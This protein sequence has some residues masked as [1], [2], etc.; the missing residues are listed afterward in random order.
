MESVAKSD[1]DIVPVSYPEDTEASVTSLARAFETDP[2]I[3]YMDSLVKDPKTA[4]IRYQNR[5]TRFRNSMERRGD[6]EIESII[7]KVVHI[8]TGDIVGGCYWVKPAPRSSEPTAE[9]ADALPAHLEPYPMVPLP[10]VEEALN[11]LAKGLDP[12]FEGKAHEFIGPDW[13][14]NW[15]NLRSLGVVPEH[16]FKGLGTKMVQWGIEL[17][18]EDARKRPGLIKGVWVAATAAGL[19]T[20]LKAGMKEVGDMMIDYGTDD[21]V[22]G[23]K[24]VYLTVEF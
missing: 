3:I 18:R 21:G 17:V 1:Y 4:G 5:I 15:W 11:R 23:P 8:P 22:A 20:Y 7:G 19:K 2:M 13:K 6:Q 9:S 14:T 16:Q 10:E 12:Q 24:Y